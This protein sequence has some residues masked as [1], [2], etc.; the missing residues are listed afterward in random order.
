MPETHSGSGVESGSDDEGTFVM[1]DDTV[2]EGVMAEVRK[3][4]DKK[5]SDIRYGM[6]WY[7]MVWYGMV[8]RVSSAPFISSIISLLIGLLSLSLA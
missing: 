7:G 5:R 3:L 8:L 4:A 6:V 2:N 1:L